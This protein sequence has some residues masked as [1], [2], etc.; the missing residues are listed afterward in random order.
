MVL[1]HV[2]PSDAC[3]L[4]VQHRSLCPR[5]SPPHVVL[6]KDAHTLTLL[7]C[8]PSSLLTMALSHGARLTVTPGLPPSTKP[9]GLGTIDVAYTLPS[10]LVVK[11]GSEGSVAMHCSLGSTHHAHPTATQDKAR[12]LKVHHTKTLAFRVRGQQTRRARFP[13][14]K[15]PN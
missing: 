4:L 15:P 8:P 13:S 5:P 6:Y 9:D 1:T 10:G 3:A 14:H 12:V 11:M 7:S 2:S